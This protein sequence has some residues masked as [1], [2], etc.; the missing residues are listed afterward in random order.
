VVHPWTGSLMALLGGRTEPGWQCGCRE[1]GGKPSAEGRAGNGFVS[2]GC[3]LQPR[4][5]GMVGRDESEHVSSLVLG[6][7]LDPVCST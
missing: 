6:K 1:S 7:W 4:D 5:E 2:S 3:K